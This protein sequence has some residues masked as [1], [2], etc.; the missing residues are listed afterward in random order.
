MTTAV[1]AFDDSMGFTKLRL[2]EL[3][4]STLDQNIYSGSSSRLQELTKEV[5]AERNKD[6]EKLKLYN[7]SLKDI[8]INIGIA[9]QDIINEL[10]LFRTTNFKELILV[11]TKESRM[12]YVGI[13]LIICAFVIF[14]FNIFSTFKLQFKATE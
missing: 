12:M 3:F 2:N 13:F 4:Q 8:F 14:I 5:N 9:L 10:M 11:F 7:L 1:S 6:Y